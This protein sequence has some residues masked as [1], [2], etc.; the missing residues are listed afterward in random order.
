MAQNPTAASTGGQTG[1]RRWDE[2]QPFF[3]RRIPLQPRGSKRLQAEGVNGD[4][5]QAFQWLRKRGIAKATSMADRSANEGLIGLRVDGIRGALVEVNS[6]T[7][8]VAR[9]AKFQEF[10]EKALVVALERAKETAEG[11]SAT[12]ELDVD[13][14]LQSEHPGSGEV[15]A[16]SLAHLVAAI[17]ENIAISRAHILSL[18][19]G[20][21][22]VSGYVHGA[23]GP[24]MGKNAAIVALKL[25][26]CRSAMANATIEAL[27]ASAKSL[28]MHVVAARPAFLNEASAPSNALERE[29]TLLL[30]QARESGKDPN[31]LDKMVQ[32]RLRKYLEDNALVRQSHMVAEGNP[33]VSDYLGV[34]GEQVGGTVTVEGFARLSVGERE[35]E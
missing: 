35:S 29:K 26:E 3:R 9:N 8:F 28:A 10:V 23:V 20:Q 22:V 4:I 11:T 25:G 19:S 21:G 15:L 17:R 33:R 31:I 18:S 14:L 2:D 32:G 5:G 16:D 7:D 12:R 27:D 30:D 6:E 1:L 34:L 13:E 24:G